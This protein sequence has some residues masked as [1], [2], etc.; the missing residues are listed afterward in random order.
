MDN[1]EITA[2]LGTKHRFEY[3]QTTKHNTENYLETW[4]LERLETWILEHLNT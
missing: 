1:P 4:T 3:K 2:T